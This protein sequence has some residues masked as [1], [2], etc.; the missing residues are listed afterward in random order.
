MV[1]LAW[2]VL[3]I[4]GVFAA[5]RNGVKEAATWQLLLA[6][7]AWTFAVHW[8]AVSVLLWA[9]T[10]WDDPGAANRLGSHGEAIVAVGVVC[11]SVAYGLWLRRLKVVWAMLAGLPLL[12]WA[13]SPAF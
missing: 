11:L 1:F 12:A 5:T 3:G 2:A 7:A 10:D 4:A 13:W 6:W 9:D 8:A